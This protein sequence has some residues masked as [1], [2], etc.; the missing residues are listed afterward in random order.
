MNRG[1]IVDA[2]TQNAFGGNPAA[3]VLLEQPADDDWMQHVAAEFNLSET[4]FVEPEGDDGIRPLR[5]FT[6]GAEVDLCGHATLA[7]GHVLGGAQ[8]FMTRSG[9]L[10]TS[11]QADG[12]IE[13][14][15]PDDVTRPYTV[16]NDLTLALN[17]TAPERAGRG[18]SDVLVEL[19]SG[20]QVRTLKPDLDRIRSIPARGVIVTAP[21]D[22]EGVDF[23]SRC[24][25]PAVGIPEDP[26]TGSAHCTLACWWSDR[27]DRSKLVGEQA[28]RRGGVVQAEVRNDRVVL[29]GQAVTIARTELL[30]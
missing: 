3:V 6:P 7:T 18:V 20:E 28:S 1:F 14:D 15:F 8:L 30:V 21:G 25:Y 4:A 19:R 23:V 26:V 5:W 2:F 13:M 10:R 9:E 11:A 24:F 12:W 29:R 16:D 27:L 17:G 22:R